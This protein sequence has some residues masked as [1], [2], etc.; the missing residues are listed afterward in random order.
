LGNST[1]TPKVE[2]KFQIART[3]QF[4]IRKT[5]KKGPCQIWIMPDKFQ[6]VVS[7]HWLPLV[8]LRIAQGSGQALKILFQE[9]K[10]FFLETLL[11]KIPFIAIIIK[12][13]QTCEL[14]TG[15]RR[16]NCFDK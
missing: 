15:R 3:E 1:K 12:V 8:Q 2:R 13:K 7:I 6:F 14:F 16:L 4:K 5:K 11:L 10:Y 9:K